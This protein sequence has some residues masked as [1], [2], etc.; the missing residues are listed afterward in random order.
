MLS[1]QFINISYRCWSYSFNSLG[2][3]FILFDHLPF[4]MGIRAFRLLGLGSYSNEG[5]CL[6]LQW[7]AYMKQTHPTYAMNSPSKGFWKGATSCSIF[8][9]SPEYAYVSINTSWFLHEQ[10]CARSIYEE[11]LSACCL[12]IKIVKLNFDWM[13]LIFLYLIVPDNFFMDTS[14]TGLL[15]AL[16]ASAKTGVILNCK[17]KAVW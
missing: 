15:S 4:L 17:V 1:L 14:S 10:H 7:A 16:R 11:N 5:N 8:K 6:L 2:I 3:Y 13:S 12:P 9:L